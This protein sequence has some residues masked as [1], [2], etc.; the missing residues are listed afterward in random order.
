MNSTLEQL[1]NASP[2]VV[3][4]A[5]VSLYGYHIKRR[6]YGR[7]F[8][9]LLAQFNEQ[10]WWSRERLREYQEEILRDLI[11]HCYENV[12]YYRRIM[13]ERGV[14]PTDIKSVEDLRLLP[15][16]HREQVR[17]H[18]EELIATNMDRSKMILGQT[19]GTTG[20]PLQFLWDE[21]I[22]L[23]KNV[24][25]WRQKAT[26]GI[27]PG[28]RIAYFLGRIVVPT[29]RTRPPFWRH[30]WT[31]N[32]L[33]FSAFHM[34]QANLVHYA[35]ELARYQPAAVEGYPSTLYVMARYL[36]SRGMTV[37]VRAALSSSETLVPEQREAIE[38]AFQCRLFDFYGMAERV[39]FATECEEHMGH[40]INKDFGIAEILDDEGNA[41]AA[42]QLARIVATGLHNRAMPLLRYLTSDVSAYKAKVCSCR[43]PFPLLDDIATK[44]EDFVTTPDGRYISASVLTHPFKSLSTIGESQITQHDLTHLVIQIVRLPGY[45]DAD[46][47]H[48]VSEFKRRLGDAMNIEVV[49]VDEI[50]RTAAGKLRWVMSK[51]PLSL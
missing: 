36:L 23:I 45:S 41:A 37:P 39:I 15:I 29:D 7:E 35:D 30:N 32:H 1:Y 5:L 21:R 48:L 34:S 11:P 43:R 12:P 38:T 31:L 47:H 26:A 8:H 6:E 4:N 13:K 19:S 27:H 18:F 51:V 17:D 22:C 24:V 50:P 40:H 46:T 10:Q 42:G 49:F 20:S 44:A 2:T 9:R 14:V 33:L 3:Q 16:L 28:D 25:D